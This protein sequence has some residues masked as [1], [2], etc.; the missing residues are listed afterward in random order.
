MVESVVRPVSWSAGKPIKG[1][2]PLSAYAPYKQLADLLTMLRTEDEEEQPPAR[3]GPSSKK[4]LSWIEQALD[5]D[6]E[7]ALNLIFDRGYQ[8]MVRFFL[9]P[10]HDEILA[11]RSRI[12]QGE[13]PPS[14]G[15][16][17]R[18][19]PVRLNASDIRPSG[20]D[21]ANVAETRGRRDHLYQLQMQLYETSK[22]IHCH[23]IV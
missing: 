3:K 21:A 15:R 9:T 20:R 2:R 13:S 1:V 7:A 10:N 11:I 12:R 14:T 18:E 4:N 23:V 6:G 22:G 8:K 17:H 16:S 19:L 5:S